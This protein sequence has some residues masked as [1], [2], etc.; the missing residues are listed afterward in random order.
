M[1]EIQCEQLIIYEITT[2]SVFGIQVSSLT[3][4]FGLVVVSGVHVNI[5]L[6]ESGRVGSSITFT[7]QHRKQ[8]FINMTF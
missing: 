4:S 3:N 7:G 5:N 8:S 6:V 2:V 1:I